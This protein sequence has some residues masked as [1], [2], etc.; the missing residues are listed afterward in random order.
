[1][2]NFTWVFKYWFI[3]NL[4]WDTENSRSWAACVNLW[5]MQCNGLFIY[6]ICYCVCQPAFRQN[7]DPE[8]IADIRID[9][10]ENEYWNCFKYSELI[11]FEICFTLKPIQFGFFVLVWEI[12]CLPEVYQAHSAMISASPLLNLSLGRKFLPCGNTSLTID[13]W[14]T[15]FMGQFQWS[16]W[17]ANATYSLCADSLQFP[18]L[19]TVFISHSM[20]VLDLSDKFSVFES[21]KSGN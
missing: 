6:T 15:A 20:C 16:T 1:M 11:W 7:R 9:T 14:K 8:I 13:Y 21:P 10:A 2:E 3:V 19:S 12:Y 5:N 4:L 17:R 18:H